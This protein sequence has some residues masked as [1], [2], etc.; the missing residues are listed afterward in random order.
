MFTN[1]H[2]WPVVKHLV[3]THFA[4]MPFIDIQDSQKRSVDRAMSPNVGPTSSG[5]EVEDQT[6]TPELE[7]DKD[8]DD[9]PDVS[10][11]NVS[12][13]LQNHGHRSDAFSGENES[14]RTMSPTEQGNS[15]SRQD[16]AR[17]T[18]REVD[19]DD[20]ESGFEEEVNSGFRWA[21]QI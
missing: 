20:C 3:D 14:Q 12:D 21:R 5:D 16:S 9:L 13:P 11:L 15:V 6:K 10:G 2:G 17:W 19:E 4:H 1:A 8:T 7:T 18:D